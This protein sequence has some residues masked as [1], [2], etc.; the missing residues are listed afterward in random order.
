MLI[1]WDLG[2]A[3]MPTEIAVRSDGLTKLTFDGCDTMLDI[4]QLDELIEFLRTARM[5]VEPL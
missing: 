5:A 1:S 4:D 2:D 3:C